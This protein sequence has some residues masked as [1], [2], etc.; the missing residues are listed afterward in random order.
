MQ[1]LLGLSAVATGQVLHQVQC[2]DCGL[3]LCNGQVWDEQGV[4][5]SK[6]Q[7]GSSL[8]LWG[9]NN[10]KDD[11]SVVHST[12][13][14]FTYVLERD[15]TAAG[16]VSQNSTSDASSTET[17]LADDSAPDGSVTTVETGTDQGVAAAEDAEQSG[18]GVFKPPSQIAWNGSPEATINYKDGFNR[19]VLVKPFY[20]ARMNPF[21]TNTKFE[22]SYLRQAAQLT[23]E[24]ILAR[25]RPKLYARLKEES[26]KAAD[27]F[28]KSES[29][30]NANAAARRGF[31]IT[32]GLLGRKAADTCGSMSKM[33][34]LPDKCTATATGM[35]DKVKP[36]A[37]SKWAR[38]AE[39]AAIDPTSKAANEAAYTSV[40]DFPIEI[41]PP[42]AYQAARVLYNKLYLEYKT[43][44]EALVS[45]TMANIEKEKVDFFEKSKKDLQKKLEKEVKDAIWD[46]PIKVANAKITDVAKEQAHFKA[47]E[48]VSSIMAPQFIRAA[49]NALML[50][51]RSAQKTAIDEWVPTWDLRSRQVNG[52]VAVKK[53][54]VGG[55]ETW[56]WNR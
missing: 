38:A 11:M 47:K 23:I 18:G 9:C 54:P 50:S 53:T 32:R 44:Y 55:S 19:P 17:T 34:A 3:S 16:P 39:K 22:D 31:E 35:F 42:A 15:D 2:N 36:L 24:K 43:K 40:R 51:V 46:Q 49:K 14:G 29:K 26:K 25:E 30:R 28:A 48:Q 33:R 20:A 13:T 10:L 6:Y 27:K 4:V 12:Q 45:K 52:L 7:V 5:E 8:A 21:L 1:L 41:M 56:D 37:T